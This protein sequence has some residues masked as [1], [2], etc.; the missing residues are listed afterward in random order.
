[1][2]RTR[3]GKSHHDL[4]EKKLYEK[5]F[6]VI[7]IM[8]SSPHDVL[9]VLVHRDVWKNNLMF[10]FDGNDGDWREPTHCVLLD[11]QTARYLPITVDVLMAIICTTRISH[12]KEFYDY[13]IQYYY[14]HLTK[15]LEKFN[16]NLSTKMPFDDYAKSCNYQKTFAL[17][18]NV[19]VLMLTMIPREYFL[20]INED[21]FRDFADGNRSK[22]I[23]DFMNKD[24][25]Y[26]ECLIESVEAVVEWIFELS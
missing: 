10:K 26:E 21:E 23:L 12:Q 22:F 16:L 8:E 5:L 20:S 14:E 18:Y 3:F 6:G 4:L 17:V 9:K 13:Y 11:F 1:M 25:F 19:I 7:K 2:N 15:E 24:S